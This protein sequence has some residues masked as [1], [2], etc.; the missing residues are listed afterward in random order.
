MIFKG[1]NLRDWQEQVWDAKEKIYQETKSMS[2]KEYL[3]YIQKGA[4][5]FLKEGRLEKQLLSN[6]CYKIA[7][8]REKKNRPTPTDKQM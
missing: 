5:A 6:G 8:D 7:K 1:R 2:F 4:S 3:N